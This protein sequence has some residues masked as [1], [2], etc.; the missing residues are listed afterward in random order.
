M[1]LKT[2]NGKVIYAPRPAL[3]GLENDFYNLYSKIPTE[4]ELEA[5][6]SFKRADKG[7]SP[8]RPE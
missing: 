1:N 7:F 3:I 8:K 5:F 2:N 6:K 4:K